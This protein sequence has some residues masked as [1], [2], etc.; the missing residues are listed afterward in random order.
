MT[1]K[2]AQQVLRNY[3]EWRRH[4]GE[5]TKCPHS[6]LEIG[7]AIDI[8][9]HVLWEIDKIYNLVIFGK[10]PITDNIQ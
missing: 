2:E 5:P 1:Y 7:A 9:C 8:A 3:N 6:A 4:E 10:G